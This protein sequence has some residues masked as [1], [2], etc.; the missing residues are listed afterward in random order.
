MALIT[1]TL[2][3]TR[4]ALRIQMRKSADQ[5]LN[6]SGQHPFVSIQAQKL[7]APGLQEARGTSHTL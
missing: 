6:P 4:G 7:R 3:K 1:K 2:F 5:T